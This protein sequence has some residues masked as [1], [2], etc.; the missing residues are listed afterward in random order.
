MSPPSSSYDAGRPRVP[1]FLVSSAGMRLALPL[2]ALVA[3]GAA[4]PSAPPGE[5][6]TARTAGFDAGR[7]GRIDAV[8]GEAV[9]ARQLPGA[10]VLVGRGDAVAYVKAYGQRAL[11]PAEETMTTDTVFDLA[12][13]TKV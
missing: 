3:V 11:V 2:V 10:V 13:L 7:L 9:Q 1:H 5:R 6:P 4:A 8:V 12:S